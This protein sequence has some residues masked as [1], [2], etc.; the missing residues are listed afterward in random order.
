MGAADTGRRNR[1]G[2]F[3][4]STKTNG[5]GAGANRLLPRG[6]RLHTRTPATHGRFVSSGVAGF[7]HVPSCEEPT[8][9]ALT[10]D[11]RGAESR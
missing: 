5:R 9:V 11:E 8:A 6:D 2:D 10:P 1:A 4:R 3:F 7:F